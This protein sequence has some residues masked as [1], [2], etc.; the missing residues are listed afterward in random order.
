MHIVSFPFIISNRRNIISERFHED[1]T[2]IVKTKTSQAEKQM[3]FH[4]IVTF[5]Y[6]YFYHLL[7]K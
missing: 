4:L 7:S 6:D 5:Y 1:D 3:T 2:P